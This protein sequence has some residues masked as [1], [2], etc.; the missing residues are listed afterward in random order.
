MHY[1]FMQPP[2]YLTN[3]NQSL[4][5]ALWLIISAPNIK[6]VPFPNL[7]IKLIESNA[8]A[9]YTIQPCECFK[10][11]FYPPNTTQIESIQ[12]SGKRRSV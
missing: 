10:S 7:L 12:D 2:S 4:D 6:N 11:T 5:C 3:L 9:Y 8:H 1:N